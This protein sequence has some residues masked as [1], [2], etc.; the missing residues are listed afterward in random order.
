MR[1]IAFVIHSLELGGAE[2]VISD[3]ANNFSEENVNAKYVDVHLLRVKSAY[4]NK[5]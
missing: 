3:L 4:V 5:G 2:R 1:K